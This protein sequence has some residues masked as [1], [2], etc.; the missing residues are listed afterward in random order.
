MKKVAYFVV[1]LLL[2][3]GLAAIGIGQEADEYKEVLNLS[4][5]GLEIIESSEEPYLK[6]NIE[7]A[8]GVLYR[9]NEPIM[10]S[11]QKKYTLPFGVEITNVESQIGEVQSMVLSNKI[12][13]A[14]QPQLAG[15]VQTE[16]EYTE[17]STIYNSNE[18]FPDNWFDYFVGVGLDDN[19]EHKTFLNVR[20]YP[21]RYSPG[22][23]TVKYI[24]DI[25]LTFSYVVPENNPFPLTADYDLAII[26]AP[27]FESEVNKLVTHKNAM[28]MQTILMTTDDIYTQYSGVD[29][30]EQIKYFIKDAIETYGIQYVLLIGGLD[31]LIYG[32]PR[33][34]RNYGIK[35]WHVP[36]RYTNLKELQGSVFDPGFLS[37]L[38]Y[39]DIYKEGGVFD[40]WDSNNDGIFAKWDNTPGKD[41]LD[42]Y[43]DVYVGR[44]ACRNKFEVKIMVN[45]II[46]YEESPAP[47][48][49]YDKIILCGGDSFDDPPT[50]YLEGEVVCERIADDY[51][52]E[53]T[54]IKLYASNKISDPDMTCEG[55]NIIRE[56]R[57]GAGHL[58]LDGHASPISWTTHWPG[59]FEGPDSWTENIIIYDFPKL[60]NGKKLPVAAVEG[61]HNNQFNVSLIESMRDKGGVLHMWTYGY[62]T[63]ECWS[64]WLTRK[65]GGGAIAT[66]GNTALGYGAVGEH[67]DLDH[68]DIIEPDILE[69]FGGF[70]F[71]QYY[72]EFDAGAIILGD[73]H[74]GALTDYCDTHP[75]MD[76]QIDAKTLEQM[77]LLGDPSLRIGGYPAGEELRV[78]IVD[79]AAGMIG[80][81]NEEVMFVATAYNSEGEVTFTWDFDDDG[82]YDDAEGEVA[83]WTWDEP[84]GYWVSVKATDDNGEDTYT[85]LVGVQ[86]GAS[87][88]TKPEGAS[89]AIPGVKYTYTTTVNS[90]GGYWNEVLYKFSWGNEEETDWKEE[91]SASHSWNPPGIY[92][93]RA[94]ALLIH[95]NEDGTTDVKESDWSD[96]LSVITPRARQFSLFQILQNFLETHPNAFPILRQVLGL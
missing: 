86:Y 58:F 35:D 80:V 82:D 73:V 64:W 28:G 46:N 7:G 25:E 62:P 94:K 27:K 6:L 63:P 72:E 42:F 75:G 85:T 9:A 16:A 91:P 66:T 59:E 38:Y 71:D 47:S 93:V 51:M 13:P 57:K 56:V 69:K 24:E 5:S 19:K 92:K 36:V 67:G 18:L 53:Y 90:I 12:V 44:L 50:N 83:S 26:T 88:P 74:S 1:G 40:D 54:Q 39:A 21:V 43:P 95:E 23:N 89:R 65:I 34:N 60:L 41:T 68:D 77:T 10:P 17:E 55:K 79:S 33:E 84:E 70:Y 49:W 45:K 76:Y 29:K 22:T 30:P 81:P 4:F 14:P 87:K 52:S 3:S 37:D 78:E 32:N 20:V 2:F 31:S 61:C 8:T 96:P 11:Y 15:A 48:S